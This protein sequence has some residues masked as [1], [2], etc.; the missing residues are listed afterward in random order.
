[1]HAIVAESAD[2]LELARSPRHHARSGRSADQG[3]RRRGQPRRSAAGRGQLSAAA[4]RQRDPRHGGVRDDRRGRRTVS[5]Q[6]QIGQQVCALLAGGGYAEFVAV[7][8]GPGHADSGRRSSLHDAAGLP[9]VACT[10]WSNLVMTADLAAGQVLL[11]HGGASGIGTHAI[12][13]ARALDAASRSPPDPPPSST[14]AANSAPR[15]LINYR[16]ED[17]VERVREATTGGRRRDP[18]HHG[19]RLPGP[20]CRRARHRRPVGRHRHAGRRQGR[21]EPRQAARQARRGHRHRA[22]VA[23]RR[24]ARAARA[25]SS[26]RWSTTCGR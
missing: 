2:Q 13:V 6:W 18:R 3:Q 16:D 11:I 7:P 24:A 17:F 5:T 14:C 26:P 8:A 22:A 9:E 23:A 10:V 21:T 12:Q 20:Q 15:S 4:G 25:R 1:M 19:R